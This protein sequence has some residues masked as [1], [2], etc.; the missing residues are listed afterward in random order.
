[1][2]IN[3]TLPL[4][5]GMKKLLTLAMLATITLS[6]PAFAQQSKS[7]IISYT[8]ED[9][10]MFTLDSYVCHHMSE[11]ANPV[12]LGVSARDLLFKEFSARYFILRGKNY[13]GNIEAMGSVVESRDEGIK[14]LCGFAFM[15]LRYLYGSLN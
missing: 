6:Q 13:T 5:L 14:Y 10:K 1:V 8:E 11:N 2:K 9:N 12:Q 3:K 7:S 15:H 4:L